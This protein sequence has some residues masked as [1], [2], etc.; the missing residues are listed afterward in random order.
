M[1]T[2]FFRQAGPVAAV[3][4]AIVAIWYAAAIFLNAPWERDQAARAEKALT[5]SALSPAR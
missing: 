2:S 5:T 4:L 1:T 3:V